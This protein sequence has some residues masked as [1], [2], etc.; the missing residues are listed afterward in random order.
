MNRTIKLLMGAVLAIL[1][2][3]AVLAV[4]T[5]AQ[6]NMAYGYPGGMGWGG[7]MGA[8][9]RGPARNHSPWIRR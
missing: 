7:M 6:E 1:V 3:T 5:F 2:L 8:G 4:G 9:S